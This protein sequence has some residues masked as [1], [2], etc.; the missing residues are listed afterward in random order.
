[1]E[2]WLMSFKYDK[3]QNV[4]FFRLCFMCIFT[5]CIEVIETFKNNYLL[6]IFDQETSRSP[7]SGSRDTPAL[8]H[9]PGGG[10]NWRQQ[11]RGI[12]GGDAGSTKVGLTHTNALRTKGIEHPDP[13]RTHFFSRYPKLAAKNHE[14]NTAGND[15]FAKFS[16]YVKNTR[17][18]KNRGENAASKPISYRIQLQ[19]WILN[20]RSCDLYLL[21]K[22]WSRL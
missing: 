20:R 2:T 18:D 12:P 11:N 6:F 13:M 17:P 1:M 21:L 19:I 9:L 10:S 14:S 7:Q 8:P 4:R 22:H 3:S 16:A 15:I 5:K